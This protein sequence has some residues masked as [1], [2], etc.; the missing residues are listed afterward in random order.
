MAPGGKVTM[1][2]EEIL[3]V[4][5]DCIGDNESYSMDSVQAK[6]IKDLIERAEDIYEVL[7]RPLE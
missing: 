5:N 3:R 7:D 1:M 4:L 2:K 6:W